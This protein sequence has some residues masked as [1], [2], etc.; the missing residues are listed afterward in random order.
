MNLKFNK[1]EV[2]ELIET[3]YKE[4]EGA[5]V[6]AS[7]KSEKSL[8]GYGMSEHVGCVVTFKVNGEIEL[9]GKK[10]KFEKVLTIEELKKLLSILLESTGFK[11]REITLDSGITDGYEGYG[12]MERSVKKSYFNGISIEG[13][14]E[15]GKQK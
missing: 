6:K 10:K 8:I 7:A 9:L 13:E 3:Y 14:R 12:V 1:K 5:T 4:F 11:A 15:F 2:L